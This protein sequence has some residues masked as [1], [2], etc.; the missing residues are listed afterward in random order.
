MDLLYIT[1]IPYE[2]LY[3]IQK[4]T[5][6]K[7]WR[8]LLLTCQ[9]LNK[10]PILVN[11]ELDNGDLSY[12]LFDLITRSSKKKINRE[13]LSRITKV[14][15][16]SDKYWLLHFAIKTGNR[17][18]ISNLINDGIYPT[19][20]EIAKIIENMSFGLLDY[21]RTFEVLNDVIND[22]EEHE[23]ILWRQPL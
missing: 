17:Y 11:Y 5:D 10:C 6:I 12:S 22:G 19:T 18:L 9:Y 14:L 7:S 20:W 23:Y 3:T 15:S 8:M 13:L 4:H 16:M 2:I 1:H 21:L